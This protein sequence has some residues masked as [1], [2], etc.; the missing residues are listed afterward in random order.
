VEDVQDF[1][2][3]SLD[4]AGKQ[5]ALARPPVASSRELREKVAGII[6]RVK[7]HGDEA[8]LALSREIEGVELT[9]VKVGEDEFARAEALVSEQ[10][11][12]ALQRAAKNIE[13]FHRAQLQGNLRV[14]TAPG[15]QCEQ[16]VRSIP[17]V[18]LYV[19]AGSAALPSAVLMLAIPAAVAGCPRRAMFTPPASDGFANPGVL[20]AARLCGVTEVYKLGGAQAVAAM[21]Y[22]TQSIARVDKIF[23]PGNAWVTAAKMAVAADPSGCTCDMPAGPSEV[24]VVADAQANPG[25]VASDLLSQA[26][27]GPDS[28]VVLVSTC[29]SVAAEVQEQLQSQLAD[30][31]RRAIASQALQCSR[32]VLVGGM[33]QAMEVVNRYAP[34]HLILQV[35]QPRVW[36]ERVHNAGSVFLGPWT[37]ESVG[38]YCSGTNHVLPTYGYARSVSGLSVADFQRRMSVQELTPAGLANIGPVARTLAQM[39]QLQGHANAVSLRLAQIAR[40]GS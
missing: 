34:E 21:A 28:Q 1:D 11:K 10:Q 5:S 22:G 31:P 12:V 19:P 20:V 2:W 7:V 37:P 13:T 30:L 15:V 16:L 4:E 39:E 38:D 17:S 35:E 26:E 33:D 6:E 18:G 25:F 36:L 29:P 3:N 32:T 27:H 14:E 8:L 40:G 23:G 9:C 24:M